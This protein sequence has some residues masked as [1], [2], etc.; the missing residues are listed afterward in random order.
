MEATTETQATTTNDGE[1]TVSTETEQSTS[2]EQSQNETQTETTEQNETTV[3]DGAPEKYE[4]KPAGEGQELDSKFLETFEGVAKELN[5]SNEKAQ[6]IIDKLSP[7]IAEQQMARIEAV[8]TEWGE[9]SRND[10]EFGGDKLK[11]NLAV[12]KTALDKFGTQELKNLMN[13]TGLGNHPE[14]VRFFF[15]AGKA[16]SQDTFVGGKSEGKVAP[17]SFNEFADALYKS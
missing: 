1:Q 9:Q 10:K 5:L 13:E 17:K 2:P 16:I 6:L 7:V 14:M 12:A 4:L 3:T 15:R 11:D 8:R